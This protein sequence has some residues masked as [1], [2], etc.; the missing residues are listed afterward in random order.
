L[1][2]NS[3]FFYH[4]AFLE[5]EADTLISRFMGP[6]ISIFRQQPEKTAIIGVLSEAGPFSTQYPQILA[7][8]LPTFLD[9]VLGHLPSAD[10]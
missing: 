7:Y 9:T 4:A 10:Q 8:Y 5:N 2:D 1:H 6:S 3:A